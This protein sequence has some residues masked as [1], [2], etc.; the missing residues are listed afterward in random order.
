MLTK[1]DSHNSVI[2]FKNHPDAH[3]AAGVVFLQKRQQIICIENSY[4]LNDY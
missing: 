2:F 3:N 4:I 1:N